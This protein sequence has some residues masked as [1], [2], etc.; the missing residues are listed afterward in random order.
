MPPFDF[1]QGDP[2][3]T[4]RTHPTN[5]WLLLG[6]NLGDRI[7]NLLAAQNHIAK[8]AGTLVAVSSLYE[9]AAWGNENQPVFLNQALHITTTL[10][11]EDLLRV[12]KSIEKTMGRKQTEKWGARLI[13]I[14]IL[15]MDAIVYD[16]PTL[17]IPHPQMHKR[18]FTLVP[19]AEIT[20]NAKHPLLKRTVKALLKICDDTLEVI[21]FNSL[22]KAASASDLNHYSPD[23]LSFGE[24]RGEA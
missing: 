23:T 12:L 1:A 24:G 5:A 10:P 22:I 17:S 19:L 7:N 18:R 15:L 14:D 9:T 8:K 4:S 21:K 20:P 16:S 6:S 3:K 2:A 13:D 11:P